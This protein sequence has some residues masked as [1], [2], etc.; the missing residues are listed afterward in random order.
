MH[1]VVVLDKQIRG[2]RGGRGSNGGLGVDVGDGEFGGHAHVGEERGEGVAALDV[3][4]AAYVVVAVG[5][6]GCGAGRCTC[7]GG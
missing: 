7:C 5:C 4:E 1:L 3:F 6:G 2:A